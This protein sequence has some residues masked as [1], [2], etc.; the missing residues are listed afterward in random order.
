MKII[1]GKDCIGISVFAMILNNKNQVLLIKKQGKDYWERPGGKVEYGEKVISALKR[2]ILEET[3]IQISVKK[4]ME[5]NEPIT[6]KGHWIGFHYLANYKKGKPRILEPNKHSDVRWFGM[7]KLPKL[8]PV[9]EVIIKRYKD[10]LK[11]K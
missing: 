11:H 2:E 10:A 8:S 3:G 9:S 6:S 5:I 4:F 7:N 1:Y